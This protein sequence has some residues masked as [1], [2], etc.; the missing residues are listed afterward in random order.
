MKDISTQQVE[1]LTKE[2]TGVIE[3]L[4]GKV[5]KTEYWGLPVPRLQ[6]QEEPQGPLYADQHRRP[7]GR[8]GRNGAP[9]GHQHDVLRWLTVKVEE[10]ETEPSVQMRKS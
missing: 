8:R 7:A 6:D 10:L 3:E 5:G 9:H 1:V 4:G 2:Y